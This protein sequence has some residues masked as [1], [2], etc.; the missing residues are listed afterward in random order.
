MVQTQR[1]GE[2]ILCRNVQRGVQLPEYLFHVVRVAGFCY[3]PGDL[4][5]IRPR[6]LFPAHFH[7]VIHPAAFLKILCGN[8]RRIIYR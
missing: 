5:G 8:P 3:G 1:P 7:H 6:F 2:T 4:A